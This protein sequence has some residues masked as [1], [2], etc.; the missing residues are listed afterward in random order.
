VVTPSDHGLLDGSV[1]DDTV[2]NDP[3]TQGDIIYADATPE[4][5]A[6]AIGG[7][8]AILHVVGGLPAWLALG[9]RGGILK[10]NA[11]ATALEYL[12]AG[13]AGAIFRMETAGND[14][15]WLAIGGARTVLRVNDGGTD[16]EFGDPID[17]ASAEIQAILDFA[18]GDLD[19]DT[20]SAN[21]VLAGPVAGAAAKPAFRALVDADIPTISDL[22][23]VGGHVHVINEDMSAMCDGAK[24]VFPLNN[25]AQP[26]TTSLFKNGSRM[27]LNDD[28]TET[29]LYNS[30]TFGAA[31]GAADDVWIDYIPVGV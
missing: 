16:T 29:D 30:V 22:S 27:R 25:E 28:Y 15:E 2:A 10:V 19:L 26:E 7:A 18:A 9:A 31:P 17:L 21:E 6:L 23:K 14:P 24:T 1:H 11:G 8:G 3:P 12:A 13:G 20:Q 4:W 5:D